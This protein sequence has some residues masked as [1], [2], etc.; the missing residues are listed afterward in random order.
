MIGE[1]LESGKNKDLGSCGVGEIDPVG[2]GI[3]EAGA[4]IRLLRHVD[5]ISFSFLPF[6]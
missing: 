3:A 4:G 2:H 6:N 5:Q 1:W